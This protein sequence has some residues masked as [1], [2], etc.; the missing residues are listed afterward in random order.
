M[1]RWTIWN[2]KMNK[3]KIAIILGT[4]AELIKMFPI[5]KE[6][7][8]QKKEYYF[9][10]TGQHNL[11]KLC[12]TF[13][14]KSPDFILSE[15]PNKSSKFFS[16]S[17]KALF[18]NLSIIIKLRK[19]LKELKELKYVIY[20]GDTM[21]TTSAAL[22]SSKL[23]NPLKKYKNVHVEAGLRSFNLK[24]PFPEEISRKI[25]DKFSDVLFAVS[26]NSVENLKKYKNSKK[27][28]NS[29]NTILDSVNFA[30]KL[31]KKENV[32]KLSSKNFALISIHRH[33]NIKNCERLSKIVEILSSLTIPAYFTLHDNTKKQLIK[34]GLYGKLKDNKNI[35]IISPIDYE[36]FI[37]QIKN[38]KLI[39]CDGGSMQEESLI[40]QKPCI[41]LRNNTERPE[42]LKS[43]FQFLSKFDV[44]KTKD[45]IEEFLS[46][47]F[48]IVKFDN[49]YGNKGVSEKIAEVLE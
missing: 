26:E 14:I 33:E 23:L 40:F 2:L 16:N 41:I 32:R 42:G 12:K 19:K 1:A 45:K 36:K 37:W 30:L 17:S 47:N 6:L 35:K 13:E 28:I 46:E 4:R 29:G 39:V 15:E 20:H 21:T 24:E 34:F 5:M 3:S 11:E 49:P 8:N 18:W 48:K 7:E 31:A 44:K 10:H 25:A 22:A 38:C 27:I 9:I 43:N